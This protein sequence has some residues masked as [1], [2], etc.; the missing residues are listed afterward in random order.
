MGSYALRRCRLPALPALLPMGL[1]VFF[2][3]I[4]VKSKVLNQ[5]MLAAAVGA[6][7]MRAEEDVR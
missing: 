6:R 3:G 1:Q 5:V 7:L 4:I 2:K